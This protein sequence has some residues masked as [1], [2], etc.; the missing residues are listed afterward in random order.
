MQY[1]VP[2]RDWQHKIFRHFC[3]GK[4]V[5][6]PQQTRVA[7]GAI[8]GKREKKF[9]LSDRLLRANE[10]NTSYYSLAHCLAF[11]HV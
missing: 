5:N 4:T 2:S 9:K 3:K 1:T 8:E 7:P 11:A 10:S 6:K